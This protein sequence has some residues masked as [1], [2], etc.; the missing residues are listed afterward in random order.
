MQSQEV[1]LLINFLGRLSSQ[2]SKAVKVD[3]S[4]SEDLKWNISSCLILTKHIFQMQVELFT[5]IW[6]SGEQFD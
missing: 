6:N 1:G 3:T 4:F 2:Q 5:W